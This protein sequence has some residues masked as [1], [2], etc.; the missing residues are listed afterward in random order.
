MDPLSE[1]GDI[2]GGTEVCHG[3][4]NG[5]LTLN[6]AAGDVL[7]WQESSSP[8]GPWSSIVNTTAELNYTNLVTTTYY[9][10]I[11]Q[12]GVCARAISSIAEVLVSPNTVTGVLTGAAE[13]CQGSNIGSLSI[14]GGVG[15]IVQWETSPTGKDP[16]NV[17][18]HT[19][20][21]LGYQNLL[22]STYYRARVKSGVCS[23]ITTN[24]VL[25]SVDDATMAGHIIGPSNEC[26]GNNSGT[27]QVID[28]LGSVRKWQSREQGGSWVDINNTSNSLNYA[29]LIITTEYR[30]FIQNG[31]CT[32][33]LT[34]PFPVKIHPLPNMAFGSGEVC[35]GNSTIFTN[36]TTIS[37]GSISSYM[38]NLGFGNVSTAVNPVFEFPRAGSFPVKLTAISKDGCTNSTTQMVVVHPNPVAD[39]AQRDICLG[40]AME[41]VD[42]STLSTGSIDHYNWDFGDG[43][44]SHLADPTHTYATPGLYTVE[45]T[46]QSAA[47]CPSIIAKDVQIFH[48]AVP[49]FE[50]TN[51]CDGESVNIANN[52]LITEGSVSYLWN[53]GDGNTSNDINPSHDYAMPGDYSILLEITSNNGCIDQIIKDITIYAQPIAKF[54]ANDVCADSPVEFENTSMITLETINYEWDFGDGNQSTDENPLHHYTSF[55]TYEVTLTTT[56]DNGCQD[57]FSNIITVEPVP[58]VNFLFSD[59][60]EEEAVKFSNLTTIASGALSYRWSFGDGSTSTDVNPTH[61]YPGDGVYPTI[62]TVTSSSKCQKILQQDVV[63]HPLPESSFTV[64]AVC[65]GL[66]SI[67][68]NHSEIVS[69]NIDSYSWDFGD[70]SNSIVNSPTHQYLNEGNYV[71]KMIATSDKGCVKEAISTAVVHDFPIAD[72]FTE[73]VCQSEVSVFENLSSVSHGAATYKWDFGDGN[74]SI[75][76]EPLHQYE[77]PDT[78]EVTLTVITNENCVDEVLRDVVI[79]PP[80]APFAGQNTTVSKGFSTQLQASGGEIYSWLPVASLNN[81]DIPNPIATPLETTIYEVL[82]TNEHGCQDVDSVKVEV[83]NDFKVIAT[84]VITP[85]G[86]GSNDTWV[87]DNIETFGSADVK[88]Y[89]RWG[90][91]VFSRLDYQNDWT[92]TAGSDILPDGTYFYTISFSDSDQVY[93]GSITIIR[94]K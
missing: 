37:E 69:G 85:D 53:F 76:I 14:V 20:T 40:E 30:A 65:D 2:S 27:L 72:F 91:V 36:G 11:V 10:A 4:N 47:S 51:V 90:N 6:N 83:I 64:D 46:I 38:W 87:I 12:N 28:G 68:E 60:C 73:D 41:F 24:I 56:A 74:S 77:L 54:E 50:V 32:E 3:M 18:D 92:G 43:N 94:N 19:Q 70:G 44:S 80:P 31:T 23:E 22:T 63:V 34:A 39:F 48:R 78:Y 79:F 89:D 61:I 17:I 33:E 7:E 9:R 35:Q 42:L 67:F 59:V 1:G 8:G 81:S 75:E 86:N 62:L 57:S 25:I 5:T 21:T 52:T 84:N 71:V 15:D 88:V 13:V 58:Q 49:D 26:L 29:N 45:L 55:G 16:W 93:K 66:P 82:V